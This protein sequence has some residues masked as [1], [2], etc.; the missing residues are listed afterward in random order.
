MTQS[1]E[2]K[3]ITMTDLADM[4]NQ[5]FDQV[6]TELGSLR[7]TTSQEFDK[8]RLEMSTMEENLENK[9]EGEAADIRRD[10]GVVRAELKT[11]M[12]KVDNRLSKL[13]INPVLQD[14]IS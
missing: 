11:D 3:K 7:L 6:D 14:A 8:V 13:E 4:M 5:R 1:K 2:K 10:I 12:T 9:I